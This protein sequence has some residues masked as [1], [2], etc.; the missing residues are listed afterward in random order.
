MVSLCLA[1][2]IILCVHKAAFCIHHINYKR[3]GIMKHI[4]KESKEK[5]ISNESPLTR[6]DSWRNHRR[7]MGLKLIRF[8]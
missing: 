6:H 8:S 5:Y 2:H 7:H 4:K 1:L 3:R